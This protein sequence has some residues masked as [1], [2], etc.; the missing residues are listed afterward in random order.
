MILILRAFVVDVAS[1]PNIT[2][3][4]PEQGPAFMATIF[5]PD[6]LHSFDD[7]TP[8]VA[9]TEIPLPVVNPAA[10]AALTR[11]IEVP[12]FTLGEPTML[13]DIDFL[14]ALPFFGMTLMVKVHLPGETETILLPAALHLVFDALDTVPDTFAPFGI[15]ICAVFANDAKE[16][17]LPA[18]TA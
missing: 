15:A 17:D 3:I 4:V 18:F 13:I 6:T 9:F 7:E 8:I 11:V 10:A 2:V 5:E 12:R 16:D 14:V 1:G